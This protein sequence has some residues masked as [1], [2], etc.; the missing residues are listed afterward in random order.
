VIAVGAAA[1]RDS[2]AATPASTGVVC[3]LPAFEGSAVDALDD[4][5]GSLV[6]A[7]LDWVTV[8]VSRFSRLAQA[9]SESE[10]K[11]RTE[12]DGFSIFT[13]A[14]MVPRLNAR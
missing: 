11:K 2:T 14:T 5:S 12:R 7:A 8:V 1:S 4:A 6:V 3:A 9:A 13:A 10:S